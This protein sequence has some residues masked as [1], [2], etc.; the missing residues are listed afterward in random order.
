MEGKEMIGTLIKASQ[1]ERRGIEDRGREGNYRGMLELVANEGLEREKI[2][3][4]R[5]LILFSWKTF[6]ISDHLS[7][8]LS[9]CL[10]I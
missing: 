8:C 6:Y 4:F 7:I 5:F 2:I 10:S 3:I 1:K 9:T